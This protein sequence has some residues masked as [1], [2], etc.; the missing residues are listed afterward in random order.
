[1]EQWHGPWFF[2]G[3]TNVDIN[4][5]TLPSANLRKGRVSRRLSTEL[6]VDQLLS[7]AG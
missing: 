6:T 5:V 7:K 1:M 4:R 2:I 3:L